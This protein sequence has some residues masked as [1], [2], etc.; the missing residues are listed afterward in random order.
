[1]KTAHRTPTASRIIHVCRMRSPYKVILIN[2]N[3]NYRSWV[4]RIVSNVVD[5]PVYEAT[6]KVAEAHVCGKS[7]LRTCEMEQAENYCQ[8]L[9]Y[10]GISSNIE[11]C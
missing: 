8:N 7:T 11:P 5:M 9:R 6:Q 4:I 2:D 10:Y 1:M 3:V